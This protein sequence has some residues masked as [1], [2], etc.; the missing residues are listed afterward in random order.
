[1]AVI[2]R[3]VDKNHTQIVKALRKFPGASVFSMAPLGSGI[4]DLCIGYLGVTVIAEVKGEKGKLNKIQQEFKDRWC[5]SEVIVLRTP[6]D[7]A[8]L[9]NN[10]DRM[11]RVFGRIPGQDV[12]L[13]HEGG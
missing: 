9:L 6:D 13:D 11:R 2:G 1:M 10:M 12:D 3:R 8:A 5:G 7:C 4:P